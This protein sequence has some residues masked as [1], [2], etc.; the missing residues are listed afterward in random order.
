MPPRPRQQIVQEFTARGETVKL[1][2]REMSELVAE[3]GDANEQE[4]RAEAAERRRRRADSR[5]GRRR[6]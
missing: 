2:M 5:Q 4:R 3:L 6:R 1:L